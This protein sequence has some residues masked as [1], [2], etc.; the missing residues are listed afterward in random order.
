MG[1]D[2]YKVIVVGAGPAGA[3]TANICARNN[4]STLM[5][6]RGEFPGSK[7]MF[8][9][10]IYQEAI[11]D[12]I[13]AFWE[14]APLERAVVRDTLWFMSE[15]SA[16][17]MGFTGLDFAKPPYN[18]FTVFKPRFDRWYASKA[19]EEGAKLMTSTLVKDLIF[20]KIGMKEKKVAGVILA[21]GKKIYSDVVVIAEG[22]VSR[23]TEKAGLRD[24]IKPKSLLLYTKELLALPKNVLEAR[25]NLEGNEGANIG[26]VGFPA[27]GAIGKGGIWTNKDTVSI[28]I[29]GYLN[30][31][32]EKGLNPYQLLERMKQHPLVNRLIKGARPVE[33][34][35]KV[36]PKGG[37]EDIPAL[38]DHGVMVTGDALMLVGGQGT[39]MALESGKA[40]GETAVQAAAKNKFTADILKAYEN[41][42]NKSYI[43]KNNLENAKT[44]HYSQTSPDSSLLLSKTLNNI[45]YKFFTESTDTTAE[46]QK[47][48]KEHLISLQPM[49]KN[50]FDILK[51]IKNWRIF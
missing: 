18:K 39:V 48:I 45:G 12:I 47:K 13:P 36:V 14:E 29:G 26:M 23:L 42:M 34:Y 4:L 5:I 16:I 28:L 50:V 43:L 7:N 6:E 17:Q 44:K 46:K 11:A 38:Y 8:G 49:K 51:G 30:Q 1:H 20:E 3:T 33:Y 25:F 32:I 10:V 27:A 31:I 22:A 24:K 2:R 40:A 15:N 35:S 21:D 19:V 41:K 37:K 9:G